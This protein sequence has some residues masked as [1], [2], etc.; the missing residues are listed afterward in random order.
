MTLA[1]RLHDFLAV[2][3]PVGA[4]VLVVE[5]WLGPHELNAAAKT[6]QAGGYQRV[7][8]TGGPIHG[9]P[10]RGG[11][12]A[13]F[14]ADYLKTRGVPAGAVTA[15]PSPMTRLDHTYH[16]ALMVREW[17]KRSGVTLEALDVFSQDTHAR[18]SRYLYRLALGPKV[19]VGI[20]SS[21]ADEYDPGRWWASRVGL[22]EVGRQAAGFA[23]VA[24]CFRPPQ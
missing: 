14:A 9:W 21:P 20:Y 15:V 24:C 4:R 1:D 2:T 7:L 22:R 11:T 13:E 17:A 18:R 19:K 23:Y 5:G 3:E 12:F 10:E 6:F 16:S 8:T